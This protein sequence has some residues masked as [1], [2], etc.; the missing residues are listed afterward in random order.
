MN[1]KTCGDCIRELQNL[2]TNADFNFKIW[3]IY[4][5]QSDREKYLKTLSEYSLFFMA[6]LSAHF[7]AMIGALCALYE[8]R[9]NTVNVS[10]TLKM[11]PVEVVESVKDKLDEAERIW[12]KI[13]L[14]GKNVFHHR[15]LE[16]NSG[17]V[18]AQAK[19]TPDDL[20]RL[21]EVS[22]EIV[23]KLSYAHDRSTHV[24]NLDPSGD[25]YALLDRLSEK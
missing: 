21:I 9:N 5:N 18:F 1:E 13:Y 22:K 24:F 23:N 14:I 6:S 7:A 10:R 12:R 15:N 2:V 19:L 3:W 25:T 16:L 17:E 11:L 8:T 4:K 20:R